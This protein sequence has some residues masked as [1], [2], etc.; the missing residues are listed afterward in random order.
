MT[1]FQQLFPFFV[2]NEEHKAHKV[3]FCKD[4]AG[5]VA[6]KFKKPG[7]L[8]VVLIT[9][10]GLLFA[11]FNTPEGHY[12]SNVSR[13]FLQLSPLTT[14]VGTYFTGSGNC[15]N[16]HG[17]DPNG[18]AL[19]DANGNDVSPVTDWQATMMANSAKDPFWKAKVRHEVLETPN[20]ATEIEDVCTD[21]HA[22][23]G[24]SEFHMTNAGDHYSMEQLGL[25]SLALDGVGCLACHG[26]EDVGL[27]DSHNGNQT[28]SE[29]QVAFG[30]FADPWSGPMLQQTGFSPVEGAHMGKSEVC[31]GCHSLFVET[32]DDDGNF[33]GSTFFEQATYHE[34]LNS[35]Y[36]E[37][38]V[39]CQ[40]CH[41]PDAGE[42]KVSSQ[43]NWLFPRPFQKHYFVG[44]NTFMLGLMRD[45]AE[46]LGMTASTSQFDTVIA[47][48]NQMLQQE[49]LSMN[50]EHLGNEL[51]SAII[52]V[53]LMN[54][55]GHKFPSGYPSRVLFLE[56]KVSDADGNILFHNGLLDDQFEIIGRNADY[57]PHY[58]V[59]RNEQE[60]QIYELVQGD[61][62]NEVTTVLERALYPIKD[63]RLPPVGFSMSHLSYDTTQ[64]A[65]AALDDENF[66]QLAGMEGSGGD[67]V[68][69]R[70]ALDG[71]VGEI[72]IEV[73]AWYQS[74]PPRW[75][76]EM[77]AYDD[78]EINAFEDAFESQ[79]NTPV[80]VGEMILD[81]T[82]AIDDY[83]VLRRV[84]IG[85]NPTTDGMV[86]VFGL[87]AGRHRIEIFDQQGREVYA[88][89]SEGSLIQ[90]P[91]TKGRYLLRIDGK[92]I[93]SLIRE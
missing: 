26:M 33:V 78:E 47:R 24:H 62:N 37:E 36:D 7:N 84:T 72:S 29:L 77:F 59:I 50:V 45:N 5:K 11:G 79:D 52:E 55:A 82:T 16:C 1:D 80:M 93:F 21:C 81:S 70:V 30:T 38:N 48:T 44:A 2:L 57:E 34:W 51:D 40:N 74:I 83:D 73:R 22:P 67:R 53:T 65:G 3:Y 63:N 6:S 28:Y 15:V 12:H 19:V 76:D 61:V 91:D 23:M 9:A 85:P 42:V 43:P 31:A 46:A 68:Q 66:N 4:M 32:V 17:S 13:A 39:E 35:I 92:R 90:L 56:F 86:R 88:G 25:D 41:M 20:L 27:R 69:Y 75:T 58:D 64:V 14:E 49:S 89:Q 10:T 60:V 87:P 8:A 71:Y 18:V 54:E